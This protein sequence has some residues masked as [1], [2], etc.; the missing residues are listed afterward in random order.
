MI[1]AAQLVAHG[2]GDYL[3]QSDW[4]AAEKRKSSLACWAHALT[5]TLP[6]LFLTRAGFALGIIYATHYVID[7]WAL[8]RYLV[9]AKN[10][11]GPWEYRHAWAD[12][13]ATGYHKDRPPWLATWLYIIADNL[14]HVLCNGLAIAYCS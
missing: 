7:R 13:S 12:C 2:I 1:T 11:I 9:W 6:F 14:L 10:L 3:L 4:M 8:A 5:Y